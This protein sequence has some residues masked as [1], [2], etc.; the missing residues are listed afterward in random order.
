MFY[1][2]VSLRGPDLLC[3]ALHVSLPT[4]GTIQQHNPQYIM[5][6]KA[7]KEWSNGGGDGI[8]PLGWAILGGKVNAV[9][10]AGGSL[11]PGLAGGRGGEGVPLEVVDDLGVDVV[12]GA[13]DR[14]ARPRSGAHDLLSNTALA[15]CTSGGPELSLVHD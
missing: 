10:V 7:E 2:F 14:Q 4:A 12:Q 9:D 8:T 13:I 6:K 15:S 11:V 1:C 3:I 5:S